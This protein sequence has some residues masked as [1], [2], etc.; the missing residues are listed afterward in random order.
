MDP[1]RSLETATQ[2]LAPYK[3]KRFRLT[4][5]L[6]NQGCL[7]LLMGWTFGA[8]C[9]KM[10]VLNLARAGIPPKFLLTELCTMFIF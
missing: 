3:R 10:Y 8:Y 1:V 6:K 9:C 7:R 5:F 4:L 2:N